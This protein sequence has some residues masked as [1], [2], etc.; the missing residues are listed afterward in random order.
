[1]WLAVASTEVGAAQHWIHEHWA[2]GLD[3]AARAAADATV[4]LD[5]AEATCPACQTVFDPAAG[6]CP[7][8]GLRFA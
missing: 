8:C 3:D 2:E 6:R 7:D 4:D 5:A 1:M